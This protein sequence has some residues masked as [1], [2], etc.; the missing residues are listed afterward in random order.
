MAAPHPD[1]LEKGHLATS[2]PSH[3]PWGVAPHSYPGL[4]LTSL[5]V[6]GMDHMEALD[7][8]GLILTSFVTYFSL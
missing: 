1:E 7:K 2:V 4:T 3:L 8:F 5:V 6:T